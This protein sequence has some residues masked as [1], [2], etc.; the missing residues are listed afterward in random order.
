MPEGDAFVKTEEVRYEYISP[1]VEELSVKALDG[2]NLS[3]NKGEFAAVIGRNGSGKSTLAKTLN[4]LLVPQSGAV[5]IKGML[6]SDRSNLLPIRQS[7]GI[8]FQNPDNQIVGTIVEDDIGFGPENLGI[9]PAEIRRRV[10]E[11]LQLVGMGKYSKYPPHFLSGGQKQKIAVAG[12][13]AMKPE[14]IVFDEATAMLDA[15]GRREVLE[16]ASKLNSEHGITVVYITHH[17][18]E[19]LNAGRVIVMDK[20]KAVMDGFPGKVLSDIEAIGQSGLKAPQISELVHS[21]NKSGMEIPSDIMYPEQL[22][23]CLTEIKDGRMRGNA[24]QPGT[25]RF[26]EGVP[27]KQECRT[28]DLKNTYEPAGMEI[29]RMD[30]VSHV[31]MRNTPFEAKA[32]ENV[33]LAIYRGEYIGIVGH[34]GSGK[35]TLMQHINGLLFPTEGRVYVD[36]TEV[37]KGPDIKKIRNKVGLVFQYPEHQLFEETVYKDIA[38]GPEKQGHSPEKVK[39]RVFEAIRLVGLDG[40]VLRR[41]PFEL[42]GGQKRRVAIAGVLAL[43][44]E[45]L[46]LDEPTAG[47]DPEGRESIM[48][49]IAELKEQRDLTV[50]LVSHDIE[51]IAR[52]SDRI[53]VLKDGRVH[54]VGTP[55]QIFARDDI[56]EMGIS[57]PPVTALMKMLKKDNPDVRDDIFTVEEARKEILR[58]FL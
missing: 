40:S 50:I 24:G 33:N 34:T 5:Y 19:V 26:A 58:W 18:D 28:A 35:S 17:M 31:Y 12:I 30:N 53:I 20:G 15:E 48:R 4:A 32:L 42:S 2:V 57:L 36:G 43:N 9:E 25:E 54:S 51:D 55:R 11:A 41:S 52:Y 45:I 3:I 39:E 46:I 38:F 37:G 8:V 22:H 56:Q 13:L 29:I 47:L 14:C 49:I 6:T 10:S 44:T 27:Q 16:I 21:L 7:V 1:N 23:A